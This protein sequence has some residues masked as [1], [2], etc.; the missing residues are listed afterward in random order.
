M[1]IKHL[2]VLLI[3]DNT[4]DIELIKVLI[5]EITDV[6]IEIVTADR[7]ETGMHLSSNRN[8]GC[9]LLDLDL[10]DSTGQ[11]TFSKLW[12]KV[13]NI[14]IVILTSLR[15]EETALKAV[16]EGAQDYLTKETLNSAL[17]LRVIEHAIARKR[18]EIKLKESFEKLQKVFKETIDALVLLIE[19][20]DPYTA[21]HQKRVSE[22]SKAI[23]VEMKLSAEQISH[24]EMAAIIHDVGK[25][26]VPPEIL[27][28]PAR[29]DPKEM[30][31]IRAHPQAALDILKKIDFPSFITRIIYQHHERIDGSGYPEGIA[32][33]A[34]LLESKIL[35]VADVVEAM[36]ADRSYRPAPGLEKA[37]DEITS[38]KNTLY[39]PQ[40]VDTC[41]Q[42]FK[43]KN[44]RF[45]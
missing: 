33:N 7:L 23:A 22:L 25:I 13:P 21:G 5:S 36:C 44:F 14:P 37:L 16:S 24:M 12:E 3:E 18:A 26:I 35:A 43:E 19:T 28:K 45:G 40:V 34:I 9:I 17:L 31:I 41:V 10:P 30:E 42:L 6:R 29:L 15:D 8:I 32:G 20:R 39:D 11:E 27:Q 38:K 1:T 2:C 4:G